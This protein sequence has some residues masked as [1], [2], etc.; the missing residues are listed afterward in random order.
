MESSEQWSKRVQEIDTAL[1]NAT[2]NV[3]VLQGHRAEAVYHLGE[4]KKAEEALAIPVE[5]PVQ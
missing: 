1:V 2:N 5:P 3:Y 4:A